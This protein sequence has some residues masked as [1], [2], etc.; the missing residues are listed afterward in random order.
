MKPHPVGRL[1]RP[2]QAEAFPHVNVS[3]ERPG[4]RDVVFSRR[5][6]QD[7]LQVARLPEDPSLGTQGV[8][9]EGPEL[10]GKPGGDDRTIRSIFRASQRSS[11]Q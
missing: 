8:P 5:H 4:V 1:D 7:G 11:R 2:H 10:Q 6:T 3:V 9:A